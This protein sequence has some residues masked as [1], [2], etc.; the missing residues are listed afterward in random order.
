LSVRLL[1]PCL[2]LTGFLSCR[3]FGA[4]LSDLSHTP[5]LLFTYKNKET[6]S[7]IEKGNRLIF[8]AAAVVLLI[9]VVVLFAMSGVVNEKKA[10]ITKLEQQ[11]NRIS[12]LMKP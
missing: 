11:L 4:A 3:L 7:N 8:V 5:N 9:C 10:V 6:R 1:P 2:S 12:L